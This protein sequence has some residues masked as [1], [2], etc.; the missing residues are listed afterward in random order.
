M[1][2]V[3]PTRCRHPAGLGLGNEARSG[4][5]CRV[6]QQELNLSFRQAVER[7]L[8]ALFCLRCAKRIRFIL[9]NASA[10]NGTRHGF[11]HHTVCGLLHRIPFWLRTAG[12]NFANSKT[13]ST[14]APAVP[15]LHGKAS[16]EPAP[17]SRGEASNPTYHWGNDLQFAA[18]RTSLHA[19]CGGIV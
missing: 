19:C 6:A 3:R 7:C 11:H 15:Q 17:S 5:Q 4:R 8:S 12:F 9:A 1:R 2:S 14:P 16:Y 18:S 13:E 10:L